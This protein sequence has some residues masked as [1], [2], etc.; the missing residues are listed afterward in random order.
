MFRRSV[1]S[2]FA[3]LVDC[4]PPGFCPWTFQAR[5]L[6]NYFLLWWISPTQDRTQALVLPAWADNSLSLNHLEIPVEHSG[7]C[8]PAFA[9]SYVSLTP[10]SLNLISSYPPEVCVW[11]WFLSSLEHLLPPSLCHRVQSSGQ[12]ASSQVEPSLQPTYPT[13]LCPSAPC[14]SGPGRPALPACHHVHLIPCTQ[15]MFCAVE[16]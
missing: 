11:D 9:F 1:V 6:S 14:P 16:P 2:N 5:I 3:T 7:L 13:L 10:S 8:K 12:R 15:S 4:S